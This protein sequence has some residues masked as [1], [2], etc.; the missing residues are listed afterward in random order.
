MPAY[1]VAPYL[2]AAMD[3]VLSQ[4]H[5]D[6]ELIVVDD[7]STDDT[8]RIAGER[9][10]RDGRVRILHRANGGIA[11]ARNDAMRA[12]TAPVFAILDSDD[13]WDPSYLETQLAI[14]EQRPDVDVVTANAWLL[15]GRHDGRSARPF[16]DARPE[17]DLAAIISDETAVFIM[18]VFRRRMYDAI[19][20]FDETFR[21]NEDYDYWLRAAAAGFRFTRNDR[22]LG[23]YRRRHDSLSADDVRMVRGILRVY[24]K[25]RGAVA[26]RPLEQALLDRQV[27]RFA[28]LL[29]EVEA[30]LALD[31]GDVAAASEHLSALHERRGGARLAIARLMARWMPGLLA[32]AYAMRRAL[33]AA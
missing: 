32:R 26:D 27:A 16:P 12:A 14:L 21:T 15:G 22:P 24:E 10:R 4:T 29:H 13:L 19:G 2:G 11:A 23:R 33:R 17:P 20:G 31:A 7:G 30:R 25:L 6:V 9:A 8:P 28:T 3:S 1:N 5:R 18:S